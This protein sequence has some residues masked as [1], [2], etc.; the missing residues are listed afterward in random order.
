MPICRPK[1]CGFTKRC[2]CAYSQPDA[3]ACKAAMTKIT[4]R[5]RAVSTPMD[6]AIT[7]PPLSARMAR[8]S[9]ESRRFWVDQ[10]AISR[11]AQIR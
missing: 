11:N 5:E 1:G 3:Q 4:M 6:S 7:R 10:T 8:P 9:R 2:M